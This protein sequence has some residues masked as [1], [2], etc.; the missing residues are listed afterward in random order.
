MRLELPHGTR[1][2]LLVMMKFHIFKRKERII[3]AHFHS[4]W[5]RIAQRFDRYGERRKKNSENVTHQADFLHFSSLLYPTGLINS[6]T[7]L[8]TVCFCTNTHP[9]YVPRVWA[10]YWLELVF[11][12]LF[13]NLRRVRVSLVRRSNFLPKNKI[14]IITAIQTR[15]LVK[16]KR[17]ASRHVILFT[18][19][20]NVLSA[21]AAR[22]STIAHFSQFPTKL[23]AERKVSDC[24]S[25]L[26]FSDKWSI[27]PGVNQ[28]FFLPSSLNCAM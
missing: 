23:K 19:N 27:P 3:V 4:V 2:R 16:R 15:L 7:W 22:H 18:F 9:R 11:I 8:N 25:F 12:L 10:V 24:K 6:S 20:L 14:I 13:V 21:D 17:C 1:Q 26:C 28:T 5:A